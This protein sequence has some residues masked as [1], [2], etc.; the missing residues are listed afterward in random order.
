MS[1]EMPAPEVHA[2]AGRLRA[3]AGRAEEIAPRLSGAGD[4]GAALQ[5]AAEV[6]L[7][8]HRAAGQALTGELDWLAATVGAIAD[9]W[10]ALDRGLL[11]ARGRGD[12]G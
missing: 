8:A 10:L 3:A 11:A 1:I 12:G 6:F 9:S 2:L 4:V 7:D 5:P